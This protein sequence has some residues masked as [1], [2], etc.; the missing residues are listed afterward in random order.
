MEK[1]L[2]E[3]VA[4]ATNTQIASFATTKANL[5]LPG[6][7]RQI[8]N[9]RLHGRVANRTGWLGLKRIIFTHPYVT[10]V[11]CACPNIG[12]NLWQDFLVTLSEHVIIP[13]PACHTGTIDV[14]WTLAK[15]ATS[16]YLEKSR[17]PYTFQITSLIIAQFP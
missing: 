5:L 9:T 3:Q 13:L 7:F 1:R 8:T 12:C 6:Y 17:R 2:F 11:T 4:N 10:R 15:E 16:P 14:Y